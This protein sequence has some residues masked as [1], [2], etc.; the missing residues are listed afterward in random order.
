[1]K[2]SSIS[3]LALLILLALAVSPFLSAQSQIA[4]DWQG[5]L[6]AG[7]TQLRLVLHIVATKDGALT[8]TLDSVDQRVNGIAVSAITLKD[9]RLSLAINAVHGSYDGTLNKD[10]TEIDGTWSQGQPLALNFKRGTVKT[11]AKPAAPT[12]IDGT[13]L[14]SLD[15]GAMKLRLV[16]EIT[17]TADGLTAKLQ[18]PRFP[19]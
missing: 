13:W 14:G 10:A 18:S 4:G 1:M 9:S 5:T 12:D 11:E 17:N 7:G 16:L 8:A 15:A 19:Y 2:D 3:K 6:N